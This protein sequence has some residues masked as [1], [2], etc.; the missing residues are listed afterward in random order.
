MVRLVGDDRLKWKDD[1]FQAHAQPDGADEENGCR[2]SS[3]FPG[4]DN[5]AFLAISHR[6]VCEFTRPRM[7]MDVAAVCDRL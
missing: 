7:G 5:A 4:D 1:E 6:R 2:S 3:T